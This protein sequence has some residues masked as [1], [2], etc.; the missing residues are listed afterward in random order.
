MSKLLKEEK[1]LPEI[2]Q[3]ISLKV[4]RFDSRHGISFHCL[5]NVICESHCFYFYFLKDIFDVDHFYFVCLS[6]LWLCWVFIV[7]RG[8][9]SNCVTQA[10]L[11]AARG[12]GCPAAC[13]ILPHGMWDLDSPPRDQTRVSCIGRRILDHWT[14]REVSHHLKITVKGT[15]CA[16]VEGWHWVSKERTVGQRLREQ[17]GSLPFAPSLSPSLYLALHL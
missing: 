8:G 1:N 17:K 5:W 15:G 14:T 2:T 13:G 3:L 11:V 4:N 9:F 16:Q 12:L 10:S 6:L 7:V